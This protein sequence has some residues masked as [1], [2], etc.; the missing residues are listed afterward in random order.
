[1]QSPFLLSLLLLGSKHPQRRQITPYKTLGQFSYQSNAS[2]KPTLQDSAGFGSALRLRHSTAN[3]SHYQL[4]ERELHRASFWPTIMR[5]ASPSR[6]YPSIRLPSYGCPVHLLQ[7][8]ANPIPDGRRRKRMRRGR[9]SSS[10]RFCKGKQH[11]ELKYC[12]FRENEQGS[13]RPSD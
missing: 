13:E 4:R 10:C 9:P 6:R 11:Q 8:T 1:M 2:I 5:R 7:P 12:S 3:L